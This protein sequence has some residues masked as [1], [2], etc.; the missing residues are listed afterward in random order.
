MRVIFSQA[1]LVP[2]SG[3]FSFFNM[4]YSTQ[5]FTVLLFMKS[6]FVDNSRTVDW[7]ILPTRDLPEAEQFMC[8]HCHKF[9]FFCAGDFRLFAAVAWR[10]S[11][12][13][14]S[15]TLAR[16]KDIVGTARLQCARCTRHFSLPLHLEVVEAYQ[17]DCAMWPKVT[18]ATL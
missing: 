11:V 7:G 13:G 16:S 17:A 2:T 3:A 10:A 18:P 5:K 12:I 6:I 8:P 9:S 4:L 14:F 1:P 15:T